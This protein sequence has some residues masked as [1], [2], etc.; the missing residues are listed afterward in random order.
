M[1]NK[2]QRQRDF[3]RKKKE[4]AKKLKEPKKPGEPIGFDYELDPYG[5]PYYKKEDDVEEAER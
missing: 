5:A 4:W 2:D 3:D 1:A